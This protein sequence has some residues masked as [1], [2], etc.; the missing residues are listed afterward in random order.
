MTRQ[1]RKISA[2]VI[3]VILTMLWLQAHAQ[4]AEEN[5]VLRGPC[6]RDSLTQVW[7]EFEAG[8][9]LL[10]ENAVADLRKHRRE[11]EVLVFLGT[12]CSDSKR[13]VPRFFQ[14]LDE[15]NNP[16]F[17]V[18]LIGLDRS[19]RDAAGLAARFHIAR[20]PTF[21]F[22]Q[23]Q[24]EIGRIVETPLRSLEENWAALLNGTLGTL[25]TAPERKALMQI[26]L[27]VHGL[28]LDTLLIA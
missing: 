15:I 24:E 25:L 8:F 19:K 3:L 10:D 23:G 20:V 6:S 26:L 9:E 14:I 4:E 2:G 1:F 28:V 5:S 18:Q 12:W 22:R 27:R 11:T 13:E 7:P 16:A 17:H 21:I